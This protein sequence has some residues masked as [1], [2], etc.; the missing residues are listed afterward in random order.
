MKNRPQ[1]RDGRLQREAGTRSGKTWN[2]MLKSVCSGQL[3]TENFQR[4]KNQLDAI[5]RTVTLTKEYN[6]SSMKETN[7]NQRDQRMTRISQGPR[8]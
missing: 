7:T 8:D 6:M 5:I 4:K 1:W 3:I 2:L